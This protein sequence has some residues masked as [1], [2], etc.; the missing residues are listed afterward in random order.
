MLPSQNLTPTLKA[1]IDF[2]ESLT[3]KSL[4]PIAINWLIIAIY[5]FGFLKQELE[6]NCN[7]KTVIA[8]KISQESHQF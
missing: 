3:S 2:T 5:R 4:A 6:E 8:L 1:K 7:G